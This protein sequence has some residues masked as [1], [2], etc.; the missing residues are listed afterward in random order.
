MIGRIG[1]LVDMEAQGVNGWD[2]LEILQIDVVLRAEE[3]AL[4]GR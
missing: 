1:A 4:A 3:D 2:G